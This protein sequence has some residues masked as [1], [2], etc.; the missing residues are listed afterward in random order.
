LRKVYNKGFSSGFLLR[1]PT[2]DD[3]SKIEHSSAT[4]SKKFIGKI[5]HY[6]SKIGVGSLHLNSGSLKIGDEIFII[7]KTTGVVKC[8]I[9]SMEISKRVVFRVRKGQEVAIE[10]PLCRK[11][12]EVY[13]VV[14]K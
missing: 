9:E 12:D 2:S 3:I 13:E 7:G 8:K 6:Y 14:K 10:I 5:T 4:Q 11:G 1:T